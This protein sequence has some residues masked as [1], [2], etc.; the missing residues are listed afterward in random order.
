MNNHLND[1]NDVD[2]EQIENENT[3]EDQNEIITEKEEANLNEAD[4][5]MNDDDEI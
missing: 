3:L 4:E 1:D 2:D 5:S